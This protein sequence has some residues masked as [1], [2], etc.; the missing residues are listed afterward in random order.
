MRNSSTIFWIAPFSLNLTDVDPNIV[1]CVYVYNITCG[2]RDLIISDCEVTVPYYSSDALS[3]GLLYNIT[4]TPK[5]YVV[6]ALNGV[7]STLMGIAQL[8]VIII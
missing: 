7:S 6:G 4:I 5:S 8:I 2:R 1:Y 3:E